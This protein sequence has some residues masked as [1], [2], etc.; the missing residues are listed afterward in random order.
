MKSGGFTNINVEHDDTYNISNVAFGHAS[1]E[2]YHVGINPVLTI[3]MPD[4]SG[5]QGNAG[6]VGCDRNDD[7]F[8]FS[9]EL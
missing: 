2:A 7:A 1:G 6:L 9:A 3:T 8:F 5:F 4:R